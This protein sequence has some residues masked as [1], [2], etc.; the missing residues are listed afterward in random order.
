M[1]IIAVKG[2]IQVM[3]FDHFPDLLSAMFNNQSLFDRRMIVRMDKVP[4][5]SAPPGP[6]LPS[7]SFCLLCSPLHRCLS[8]FLSKTLVPYLTD[9][10]LSAFLR[11]T[12]RFTQGWGGQGQVQL[13]PSSVRTVIPTS[14]N[15]VLPIA[16]AMTL[17]ILMMEFVISS[18]LLAQSNPD[19]KLLTLQT[20]CF[21]PN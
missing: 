21:S 2:R 6:K 19:L 12:L 11:K 15:A 4:E 1:A 16:L 18:R 17:R 5:D 9:V 14:A 3:N 13:F 20:F 8:A 7:E 10:S